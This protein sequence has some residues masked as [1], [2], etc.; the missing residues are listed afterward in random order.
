MRGD[1]FLWALLIFLFGG[2]VVLAWHHDE[3]E[4]MGL[5]LD[6][7]ARLVALLSL[8]AVVGA[9]AWR[10]LRGSMTQA[11]RAAAFWMVIAA[12]LAVVYA[13]R[14]P[15]RQVADRVLGEAIPGY[16]VS[17]GEPDT[18]EI[19]RS[20]NRSFAVRATINGAAVTL[21]L[22]TGASAVVLTQEDARAAGLNTGGLRYDV[23]VDTANGRTRAAG[24]VLD[25]VTVGSIT[26]RNV[27]ALVSPEGALRTSL[28]GMSFLSR[29]DGFEISGDRLILRGAAR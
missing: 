17:S 24:V 23:T 11:L 14:D 12:T 2:V 21:M 15:L 26:E 25:R 5:R 16:A 10:T 9:V 7:I 29:L 13:Y 4:V 20:A 28:L 27:R 8:M 3:G 22:D 6:Q 19:V 18:V 1:R